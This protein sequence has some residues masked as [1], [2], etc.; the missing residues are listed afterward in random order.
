VIRGVLR[1][2]YSGALRMRDVD[3]YA[4]VY[5][6]SLGGWGQDE[7]KGLR[8]VPDKAPTKF[9]AEKKNIAD[10][11]IRMVSAHASKIFETLKVDDDDSEVV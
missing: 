3:F 11:Y 1:G 5:L 7:L 8:K 10:T 9:T 4:R 6:D 2:A